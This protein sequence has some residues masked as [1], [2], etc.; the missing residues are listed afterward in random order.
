MEKLVPELVAE[1]LFTHDC[2]II[3]GFGGFISRQAPA[4]VRPG[5]HS[6]HPPS[7]SVLF[8]KNLV[9]NDGLLANAIIEKFQMPY[10]EAVTLIAGFAESAHRFLQ[11][12]QRLEFDQIGVLY[13]DSEKNIQFEPLEDL[14]FLSASFG[15]T[16]VYA[17]PVI[18]EPE[19]IKQ[20]EK[21]VQLQD[22]KQPVIEKIP[23]KKRSVW[24][25]AAV[26]A[27][28]FLLLGFFIATSVAPPESALASL[29]PFAGHE[30]PRYKQDNFK[31]PEIK[32]EK[33]IK[34]V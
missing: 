1:M 32:E 25:L 26:I 4:H 17:R 28:I 31:L 10:Q 12:H 5:I 30:Q 20:E 18:R 9:N 21:P 22:R 7:K 16:A 19:I 13:L 24:V 15:L 11:Q 2:V 8:N 6:V 27:P 3:P 34:E 14:N 23:V 33:N 29:N